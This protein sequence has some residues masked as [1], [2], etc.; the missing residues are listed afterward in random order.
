M[1]AMLDPVLAQAQSIA[2]SQAA[3]AQVAHLRR[4]A[5]SSPIT[6]TPPP[7]TQAANEVSRQ[8]AITRSLMDHNTRMADLT[9]GLVRAMNRH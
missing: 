6:Y 7:Q 2:M 5:T 1:L 9:T 8:N 3:A 4:Q